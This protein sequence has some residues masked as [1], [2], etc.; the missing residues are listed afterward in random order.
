MQQLFQFILAFLV[1]DSDK[2]Y[3]DVCLMENYYFFYVV[4][5]SSRFP[6]IQEYCDR[7]RRRFRKRRKRYVYWS[8]EYEVASVFF[9]VW[10]PWDDFKILKVY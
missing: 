2:K 3:V 9:K 5:D 4:F 6:S 7:A 10:A 1:S 8:L